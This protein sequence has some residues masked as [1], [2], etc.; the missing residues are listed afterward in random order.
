MKTTASHAEVEHLRADLEDT[1]TELK[2]LRE[3]FESARLELD[4]LHVYLNTN[5]SQV[6]QSTRHRA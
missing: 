5:P 6:K 1:R 3:Q 4:R 2:R